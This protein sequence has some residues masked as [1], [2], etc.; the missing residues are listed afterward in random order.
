M[1]S[2]IPHAMCVRFAGGENPAL[3]APCP[4]ADRRIY[5]GIRGAYGSAMRLAQTD[6]EA[7]LGFLSEADASGA[8]EAYGSAVLEHLQRLISCDRIGYQQADVDSRHFTDP[9]AH[10]YEDED[11]VYWSSGPCPITEYRVRTGDVSAM[12]MSDVISRHRYHDLP[13]YREYFAPRG[14]DHVLDLGLSSAAAT[15]RTLI[16]FREPDVP[17]F[18]ERERAMLEILRPHFRARE[19]RAMLLGL[20]AGRLRLLEERGGVDDLQLTTREREIVAAAAAGK[21]NAQIAAELWISPGTVKKHLE[22][23]Y[24]KLGVGN[25]AAAASRLQSEAARSLG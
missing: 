25:R 8:E 12:R 17:D 10:L 15:Y 5:V 11:A 4:F 23:T 20:V 6:L 9:E 3:D 13:V 21:T 14:L 22:N 1:S 7:I 19:A 24:V 18:S 2:C 16:L